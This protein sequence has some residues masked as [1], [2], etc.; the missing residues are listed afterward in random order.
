M[1]K[2]MVIRSDGPK[3]GGLN[4]LRL[5]S[6]VM[7]QVYD[8]DILDI[9]GCRAFEMAQGVRKDTFYSYNVIREMSES[10]TGL[11]GESRH[12]VFVHQ[13][14]GERCFAGFRKRHKK[15]K[16]APSGREYMVTPFS[17]LD[18]YTANRKK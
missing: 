17:V 15:I 8:A 12:I 18:Y 16:I 6:S 4:F 14:P 9:R 11:D 5:S 3:I 2:R 7:N 13:K 10:I 1:K